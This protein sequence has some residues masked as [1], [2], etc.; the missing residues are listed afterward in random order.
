MNSDQVKALFVARQAAMT[1]SPILP[2]PALQPQI[3]RDSRLSTFPE[4]KKLF[5]S[6]TLYDNQQMLVAL[7][8]QSFATSPPAF[9]REKKVGVVKLYD[10]IARVRC[11]LPS[12]FAFLQYTVGV[13][14]STPFQ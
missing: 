3:E 11:V 13:E 14:Y 6:R 4:R 7:A 5:L 9:L 1:N 12:Q 10:D 2:S 8:K